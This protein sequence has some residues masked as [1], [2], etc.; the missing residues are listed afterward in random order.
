MRWSSWRGCRTRPENSRCGAS[1][2]FIVACLPLTQ[3]CFCRL[4]DAAEHGG[5]DLIRKR[6]AEQ[7]E[8]IK[9]LIEVLWLT[10][11]GRG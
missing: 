9:P 2:R 8:V 1:L 3:P 4:K 10:L 6:I 7:L 11:M 5:M